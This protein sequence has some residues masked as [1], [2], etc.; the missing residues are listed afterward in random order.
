MLLVRCFLQQNTCRLS[1]K[2]SQTLSEEKEG[3][4]IMIKIDRNA[5]ILI[6]SSGPEKSQVKPV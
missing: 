5:V 4:E 3:E 6:E 2:L 1:E